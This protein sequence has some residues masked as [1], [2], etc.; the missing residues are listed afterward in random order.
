MTLPKDAHSEESLRPYNPGQS[1]AEFTTPLVPDEPMGSKSGRSVI[2]LARKYQN[3]V[4]QIRLLEVEN[5]NLRNQMAGRIS[6]TVDL[7]NS[8]TSI[9]DFIENSK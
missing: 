4:R 5:D 6:E 1:T 3:N 8:L 9:L 7:R 2:D